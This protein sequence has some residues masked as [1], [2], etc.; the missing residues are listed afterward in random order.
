M[1]QIKSYIVKAYPLSSHVVFKVKE[2]KMFEETMQKTQA[3]NEFLKKQKEKIMASWA[4]FL[5]EDKPG[6]SPRENLDVDFKI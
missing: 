4:S 3:Q 2:W 6:E 1:N 5:K